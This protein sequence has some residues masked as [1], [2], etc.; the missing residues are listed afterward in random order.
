MRQI[1]PARRP[2]SRPLDIRDVSDGGLDLTIEAT[3]DERAAIAAESGLPAVGGLSACYRVDRRAGDR[4]AVTGTLKAKI[5][6]VCIVSLEPFDSDVEQPIDLVFAPLARPMEHQG[7]REDRRR[8]RHE[9]RRRGPTPGAAPP[10]PSS[11]DQDP[12]DPIIDETIDLGVVAL[13]FLTLSLDLYPRK[14][15]VHFADLVIGE[16]D[17]KPS[18]FSALE[19]FKDR[20]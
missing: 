14:P 11:E 4:F 15:G 3:P 7:H 5:T 18:T 8:R 16:E 10:T 2:F 20:S 19:R 9:D 17:P 13:E 1:H 6:Q 12:P